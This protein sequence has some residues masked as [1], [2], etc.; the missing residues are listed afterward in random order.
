MGLRQI[1]DKLNSEH[2]MLEQG[3]PLLEK[4][5]V[6]FFVEARK[7]IEQ[8]DRKADFPAL[9]FYA[10]WVM[11]PRIDRIPSF[12]RDVFES[13][14]EKLDEFIKMEHLK[15]E[16]VRFLS[17]FD[18]APVVVSDTHWGIFTRNLIDVLSEQPLIL[19]GE[20]KRFTF[21]AMPGAGISYSMD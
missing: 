9:N 17:E 3:M 6:Y 18:V 5:V 2:A 4:D 21:L 12:V 8:A 16:L 11:H 13:Y 10:N 14:E 7:A 20:V 19:R 1:K 15:N